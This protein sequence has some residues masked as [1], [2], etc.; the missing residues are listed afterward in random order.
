MLEHTYVD[1][2]QLSKDGK[3]FKWDI[4]IFCTCCGHKL[5]GHGYVGRYFDGFT[6]KLWLKKLRC[7]N[8]RKIITLMPSGYLKYYQSSFFKIYLTI[9]HRLK[10]HRWPSWMNR[11]RG[12][13]WLN[14]LKNYCMA[15]YGPNSEGLDLKLKIFELYQ[16]NINFLTS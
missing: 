4:P 13:H 10:A 11:Q 6:E 16:N 9:Y 3:D 1:L 15:H 2:S 7:P 5:W 12:C 14:K 8:C